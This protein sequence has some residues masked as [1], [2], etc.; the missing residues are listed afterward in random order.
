[1]KQVFIDLATEEVNELIREEDA[2]A[3]EKLAKRAP[4]VDLKKELAKLATESMTEDALKKLADRLEKASPEELKKHAL[5]LVK[6]ANHIAKAKGHLEKAQAA[7]EKMGEHID[8][9][10]D[11]L[12][13]FT[14]GELEK[15]KADHVHGHLDGIEEQHGKMEEHHDNLEGSL[16]AAEAAA[17]NEEDE[18]LAANKKGLGARE[19]RKM[20]KD[21]DRKL[22]GLK[23]SQ[24]DALE[25]LFVGLGKV[26]SPAAGGI[27]GAEP[28]PVRTAAAATVEKTQ[29]GTGAPAQAV[30]KAAAPDS[31][32]SAGEVKPV[33]PNGMPNPAYVHKAAASDGSASQEILKKA[34]QQ[35]GNPFP[36]GFAKA[37]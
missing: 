27:Q 4:Q 21:F 2:K 8:G 37:M 33:L 3:A 22:E 30:S 15:A 19:L 5:Q 36:E 25:K 12:G 31:S 9:M 13:K 17:S 6:A 20:Q 32:A 7:H 10:K 34:V 14:S 23:K 16:D 1:L 11:C 35:S 28:V 18:H 26:L 24:E 29:D